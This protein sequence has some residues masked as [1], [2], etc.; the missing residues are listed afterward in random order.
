MRAKL[1]TLAEKSEKPFRK[2]YASGLASDENRRPSMIN[3]YPTSLS[4]VDQSTL[5]IQWSDA[6]RKRYRVSEL[7]G[8][9]PCATCA[10]VRRGET[11]EQ[12]GTVDSPLKITQMSPVGNYGYKI[13]FSDGHSTGIYPLDLLYDLGKSEPAG[14]S[15]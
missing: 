3:S 6:T 7:R 5:E 4:L 11:P 15:P 1:V 14:S 12:W 2:S 8:N 13:H 9:C 10:S